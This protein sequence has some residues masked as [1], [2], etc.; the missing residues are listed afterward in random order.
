MPSHS[1]RERDQL[2]RVGPLSGRGRQ[3]QRPLALPKGFQLLAVGWRPGLS[4]F[5]F[6]FLRR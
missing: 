2:K 5:P 4:L 1:T 6:F 3:R